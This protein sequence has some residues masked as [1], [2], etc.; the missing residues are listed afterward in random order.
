M[1][2]FIDTWDEDS[3]SNTYVGQL[4]T[5]DLE[6]PTNSA[7]HRSLALTLELLFHTG[8]RHHIS[9]QRRLSNTGCPLKLL[10]QTH[11]ITS[12]RWNETIGIVSLF[13]FCG[14]SIVYCLTTCTP[15]RSWHVVIL[16]HHRNQQTVKSNPKAQ[17]RKRNT[18][19]HEL[20]SRASWKEGSH[21]YQK[22]KRPFRHQP[23]R[24]RSLRASASSRRRF[25]SRT[26]NVHR[27]CTSE[28]TRRTLTEQNPILRRRWS[29]RRNAS[30]RSTT[31]R[32]RGFF[33]RRR[34]RSCRGRFGWRI[35]KKRERLRTSGVR[36]RGGI[37]GNPFPPCGSAIIG[38]SLL[39]VPN[40]NKWH[41][42]FS[43]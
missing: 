41:L 26:G 36:W 20:H 13:L 42:I 16:Q 23:K 27:S 40:N 32:P 2:S 8:P 28:R 37:C 17:K 38:W 21:R 30:C 39:I 24:W 18:R 9:K 15:T 4:L 6:L 5:A 31:H 29:P 22:P 1:S 33:C 25:Q 19:N 3:C 10:M 43:A 12:T 14:V 11:W 34:I 7:E 35:V